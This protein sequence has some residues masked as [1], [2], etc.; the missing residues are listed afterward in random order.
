MTTF[1]IKHGLKMIRT[2]FEDWEDFQ[3]ELVLMQ[4]KSKLSP[5][6]IRILKL[7]EKE[8]DASPDHGVTW[9]EV[10]AGIRRT[11]V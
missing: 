4:E 7:R 5:D 8:A 3:T 11:N 6:H 10:K 9:D 2:H 1:T